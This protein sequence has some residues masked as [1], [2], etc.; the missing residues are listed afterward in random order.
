MCG[1]LSYFKAQVSSLTH[2]S[3]VYRLRI[4][5]FQAGE[6]GS[7]PIRAIEQAGDWR[8]ETGGTK[9]SKL[10]FEVHVWR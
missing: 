10:N 3:F 1:F 8:L 9:K 7:I 6:M 4:L 5:A 2:G